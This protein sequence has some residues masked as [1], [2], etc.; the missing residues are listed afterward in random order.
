[1]LP[2]GLVERASTAAPHNRQPCMS[3]TLPRR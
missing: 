1:V 3:E 2:T